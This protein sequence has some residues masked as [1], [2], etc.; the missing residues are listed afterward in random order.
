[1]GEAFT[2][3]AQSRDR[4]GGAVGQ[5]V[6]SGR[7]AGREERLSWPTLVRTY[8][9]DG[10]LTDCCRGGNPCY[11]STVPTGLVAPRNV[12]PEPGAR[13]SSPRSAPGAAKRPPRK[14]VVHTSI[15]AHAD[16]RPPVGNSPLVGSVASRY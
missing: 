10:D 3:P 12:S 15:C 9:L 14:R 4:E 6:F 1:V 11:S 13:D 2:A 5:R 7:A 16:V 8:Y